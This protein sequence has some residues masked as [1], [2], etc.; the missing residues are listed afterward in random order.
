MGKA[1]ELNTTHEIVKEVLTHFPAAR[2]SD[3][4]LYM[5]VCERIDAISINLSF[6]DI[7]LNRKE[8]GYPAYTSVARAGRKVRR[9]HPELSGNSTV[10]GH[11]KVNE[12]IFK[13]YAQKL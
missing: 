9:R 6:K 12:Q 8:H 2:N 10:E 3:D 1:T 7:I 5:M 13:E 4:V 11:R